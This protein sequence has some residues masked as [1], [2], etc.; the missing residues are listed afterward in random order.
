MSVQKKSL[1]K[2]NIEIIKVSI[3]SMPGH[4]KNIYKPPP[5][6]YIRKRIDVEIPAREKYIT[7]VGPRKSSVYARNVCEQIIESLRDYS[8]CIVSGLA[9]GIDAIAHTHA[10]KNNIACI[11]FPGSGIEDSV[12]YPK[13]NYSLAHDILKSGG[14]LMCEWNTSLCAATWTFPARNR[15]MAGIADAVI[16]IEAGDKSG[17]LITTRY[18]LAEGRDVF[19]VPADITRAEAKGSNRLIQEGA[20]PITSTDELPELLKLQPLENK[21]TSSS[22][23]IL[24]KENSSQGTFSNTLGAFSQKILTAL[25][26]PKNTS[27]LSTELQHGVS[28]VLAHL[29]D[30]ELDDLVIRDGSLWLRK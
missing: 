5:T 4:L 18:A 20:H 3:K 9:Y 2:S 23:S 30:L 16:I 26:S 6:L 11:A 14:A 13:H 7:I 12:L 25:S 28:E 8:V 15:L 22:V 27:Q 1:Q 19:V 21:K 29:Q 10:L 24:A 17:T